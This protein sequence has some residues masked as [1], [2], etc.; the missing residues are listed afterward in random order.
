MLAAPCSGRGAI[1]FWRAASR[2]GAAV[3]ASR[4]RRCPCALPP[5]PPPFSLHHASHALLPE[6]FRDCRTRRDGLQAETLVLF[7]AGVLLSTVISA[8]GMTTA[9]R[10]HEHEKP[11]VQLQAD[12]H[13]H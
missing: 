11:G 13:G 8:L 2:A 5:P 4:A 7:I 1:D 10:G 9:T 12:P 3:R 6:V